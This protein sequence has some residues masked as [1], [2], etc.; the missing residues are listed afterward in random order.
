MAD[1]AFRCTPAINR[2]YNQL[3][4]EL[5]QETEWSERYMVL[6]DQVRNLPGFPRHYNEEVDTVVTVVVD[7]PRVGYTASV[8]HIIN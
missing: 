8:G 6:L 2:E 3:L 4:S 1:V 7:V 5:L